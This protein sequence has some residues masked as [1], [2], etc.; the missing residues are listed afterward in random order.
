MKMEQKLRAFE[1]WFGAGQQAY[2]LRAWFGGIS[3]QSLLIAAIG[4]TPPTLPNPEILPQA[5]SPPPQPFRSERAMDESHVVLVSNFELGFWAL[6]LWGL[7]FR[8]RV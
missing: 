1:G 8:A 4:G 6:C 2:V 7:G 5:S 3:K